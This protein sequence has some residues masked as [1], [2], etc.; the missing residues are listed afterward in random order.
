MKKLTT[1]FFLFLMLAAPLVLAQTRATNDP[2]G[3]R[4]VKEPGCGGWMTSVEV[5]PFDSKHILVG[6][7]M[8]SIGLSH[9]RGERGS[10]F[11]DFTPLR[12]ATRRSTRRTRRRSGRGP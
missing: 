12:S 6:G 9:D 4:P 10:R 8:L 5:S 3:W 11:S 7:D 1:L 2:N